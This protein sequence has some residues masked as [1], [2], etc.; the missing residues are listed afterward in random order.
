MKQ[1]GHDALGITGKINQRLQHNN[2][3]VQISNKS[4]QTVISVASLRIHRYNLLIEQARLDVN[5]NI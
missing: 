5:F 1:I 2:A 4:I 3:M